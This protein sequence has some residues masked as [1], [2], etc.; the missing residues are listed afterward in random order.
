VTK[1]RARSGRTSAV[2]AGGVALALALVAGTVFMSTRHEADAPGTGRA[3]GDGVLAP[4]RV[5]PTAA[6]GAGALPGPMPWLSAA[7]DAIGA[8]RAAL[9]AQLRASSSPIDAL[10]LFGLLED[11]REVRQGSS[12]DVAAC[13]GISD[14]AMAGRLD[15]L[16]RAVR[17][18]APGAVARLYE[19]GPAGDFQHDPARAQGDA[20]RARL[21]PLL[22]DAIRQ[23][24]IPALGAAMLEYDIGIDFPR[25]PMRALTYVLVATHIERA[26]GR[27]VSGLALQAARLSGELTPQ[28]R[29][30]AAT[31]AQRLFL[32]AFQRGGAGGPAP[33]PAQ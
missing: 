5:S 23:G 26:Q 7:T 33:G 14:E 17:G 31:D 13:S 28:Q 16:Q 30:I 29:S 3:D 11:C 18:R 15:A 12:N 2:E 21:E 22:V 25:D 24:D 4:S 10:R 32:D 19:A 20:W 27:D 8:Q 6:A 1:A 9:V